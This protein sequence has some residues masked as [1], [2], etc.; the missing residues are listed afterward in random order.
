[1]YLLY[2]DESG[3]Q[4]DARHFV[5]AGVAIHEHSVYWATEQLN[6]LQEQYFP[7]ADG[8]GVQFHATL[9]RGN[10]SHPIAGPLGSLVPATRHDI[11]AQLYEIVQGMYGRL[12]AVVIEKAG[13]AGADDPYERALEEILYRFDRFLSRMHRDNNRRNKGLVVIADSQDRNKLERASQQFLTGGT[14]RGKV[15]NIQDIPFFTRSRNSRPLQI[16]DLVANTV[17]GRYEHGYATQFDRLLPKFDQIRNG[18]VHG[19]VHLP[20]E[21]APCYQPCCRP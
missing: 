1:M 3:T 13:L 4:S 12:F 20:A 17:Y 19:L 2:L 6:R 16:A 11:L 5:L 18:P 7:L 10:P 21:P 9:L 8:E 15:H 14:R